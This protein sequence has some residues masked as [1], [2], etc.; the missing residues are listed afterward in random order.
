MCVEMCVVQLNIEEGE[1][2]ELHRTFDYL[3]L[4]TYQRVDNFFSHTLNF[5]IT[6]DSYT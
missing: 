6:V 5:L 1:F 4:L 3:R 2:V